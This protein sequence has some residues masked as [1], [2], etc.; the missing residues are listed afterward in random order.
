MP[1]RAVLDEDAT[2]ALPFDLCTSEE[3]LSPAL[4]LLNVAAGAGWLCSAPAEACASFAAF[5]YC[6]RFLFLS[7]LFL[8]LGSIA[9]CAEADGPAVDDPASR[10]RRISTTLLRSLVAR[11]SSIASGG[12]SLTMSIEDLMPPLTPFRDMSAPLSW[13]RPAIARTLGGSRSVGVVFIVRVAC[14]IW[15]RDTVLPGACCTAS[16]IMSTSG[17][18]TAKMQCHPL[19]V[20]FWILRLQH[21]GVR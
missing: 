5:C 18:R 10:F 3:R 14:F 8:F 17:S 7:L 1:G 2:P 12:K 9:S 20:Q 11:I 19:V 21:V 16:I 6:F 13:R 4:P 15:F